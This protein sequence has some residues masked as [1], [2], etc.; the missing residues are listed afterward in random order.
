[1][2]WQREVGSYGLRPASQDTHTLALWEGQREWLLKVI[3]QIL[4][5]RKQVNLDFA[6][7]QADPAKKTWTWPE[8]RARLFKAYPMEMIRKTKITHDGAKKEMLRYIEDRWMAIFELPL[9]PDSLPMC[10][11]VKHD[12]DEAVQ[13]ATAVIL[14]A[15]WLLL[16]WI[17]DD[18][19]SRH[20]KASKA[21][22]DGSLTWN[23]VVLSQVG[24]PFNAHPYWKDKLDE[25]KSV[26]EALKFEP[27]YLKPGKDDLRAAGQEGVLMAAKF[28]A[29][30]KDMIDKKEARDEALAQGAGWFSVFYSGG[31]GEGFYN[32][33]PTMR[34]A[35]GG[36]PRNIDD[37]KSEPLGALPP[38]KLDDLRKMQSSKESVKEK[39]KPP[40]VNKEVEA[41]RKELHEENKEKKGHTPKEERDAAVKKIVKKKIPDEKQRKLAEDAVQAALKGLPVAT[42]QQAVEQAL[43]EVL[44]YMQLHRLKVGPNGGG[45]PG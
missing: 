22:E 26:L 31:E 42:Q 20:D 14:D 39:P 15:V 9:A 44:K 24:A 30:L 16:P 37:P 1:M 13:R 41:L 11:P 45:S 33:F 8:V 40:L 10:N 29:V 34:Q 5:E 27:R 3:D 12:E 7:Q 38:L 4:R 21:L 32:P 23:L 19:Q 36:V 17:R 2:E 28:L 6:E 43:E 35:R 25:L 18:I